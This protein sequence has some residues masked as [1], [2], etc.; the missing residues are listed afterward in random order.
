VRSRTWVGAALAAVCLALAGCGGGGGSSQAGST[1]GTTTRTTT[2]STVPLEGSVVRVDRTWTCRKQVDLELVRVTMTPAAGRSRRTADAIH[3]RPGCT[4]RIGRIEVT[5]SAGDGVKVAEGVHDLEVGGGFVRCLAKAP[6]LHQDG[7]QVLGG[8]RITFRDLRVDC[9]RAG[10]RLI[11]SN[12]FIN[13]AGRS[14]HPPTDVVCDHCSF[15]GDAAHTVNIQ[16]SVRS[17]IVDSTLCPAKY[18]K[19]TL[20]VGALAEEPLTSGNELGRCAG[21]EVGQPVEPH[22]QGGSR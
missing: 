16:N 13:Q 20:T 9:G 21:L 6:R 15:G 19:L 22:L 12:L 1:A 17:G 2:G 3:L 11:N 7:V 14:T 4:G 10:E 5:Q 8:D 18:E